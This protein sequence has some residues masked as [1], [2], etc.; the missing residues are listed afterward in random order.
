VVG[1]H[2]GLQSKAGHWLEA[3]DMAVNRHLPATTI[4]KV[5]PTPNVSSAP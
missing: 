4:R 2:A 3:L 5:I 1:Y